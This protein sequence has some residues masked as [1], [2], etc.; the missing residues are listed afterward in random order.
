MK[1]S[2]GEFIRY[3]SQV[4]CKDCKKNIFPTKFAID[5][6]TWDLKCSCGKAVYLHPLREERILEVKNKSDE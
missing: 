2:T 6:D 3:P 5:P 4:F 1:T